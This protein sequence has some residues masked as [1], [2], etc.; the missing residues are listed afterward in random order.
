MPA[1]VFDM[2][3]LPAIESLGWKFT[4][5]PD[6]VAATNW[7]GFF[8]SRPPTF[9]A[10]ANWRFLEFPLHAHLLNSAD[11]ARIGWIIEFAVQGKQTKAANLKNCKE[12]FWAFAAYIKEHGKLPL[13]II[14]TISR[15]VIEIVDGFHRLAALFFLERAAGFR[16]PIWAPVSPR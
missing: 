10:K 12:R 7:D 11:Q 2:W 15:G 1:E 14:A 16:L 5:V 8:G 13:P 4:V 9:W 3:M 6:S